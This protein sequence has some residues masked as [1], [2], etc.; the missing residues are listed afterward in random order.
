MAEN[1]PALHD[2]VK[3]AGAMPVGDQ[4]LFTLE[5]V[6]EL[7][8]LVDPGALELIALHDRAQAAGKKCLILC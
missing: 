4:Y 8:H 7:V 6:A 2:L 5:Q 1:R 3:L